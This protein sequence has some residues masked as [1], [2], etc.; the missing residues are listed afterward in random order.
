MS[1]LNLKS[2]NNTVRNLAENLINSNRN[3]MDV[4]ELQN[5]ASTIRKTAI[6]SLIVN[7]I[8][9]IAVAYAAYAFYMSDMYLKMLQ[10]SGQVRFLKNFSKTIILLFEHSDRIASKIPSAYNTISLASNTHALS[11]TKNLL[12]N[13][14]KTLG[15]YKTLGLSKSNVPRMTSAIISGAILNMMPM[16]GGKYIGQASMKGA[17]SAL[18]T[19]SKMKE[20]DI[21]RAYL[22]GTV[23]GGFGFLRD[24]IEFF[25]RQAMQQ[26]AVTVISAITVYGGETMKAS[27]KILKPLNYRKTLM[28]R[29]KNSN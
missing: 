4:S 24:T 5:E 6:R 3:I 16:K 1:S 9:A 12:L 8:A 15:R 17:V 26:A 11:F 25:T 22:T 13:P 28:I 21:E 10:P 20:K 2:N 27:K 29:G 18:K 7:L 19:L 14:R 23:I